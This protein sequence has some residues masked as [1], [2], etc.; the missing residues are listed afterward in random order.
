MPYRL[1][2][3]TILTAFSLLVIGGVVLAAD[4]A[5]AKNADVW[6]VIASRLS[7]SGLLDK[8]R[9]GEGQ[10]CVEAV[11][12]ANEGRTQEEIYDPAYLRDVESVLK[13]G[14]ESGHGPSCGYVASLY[15]TGVGVDKDPAAE[16]R[17]WTK[18]CDL[19]DAD[20]CG[21]LG[22]NYAHGR[23]VAVQAETGAELTR[24]ACFQGVNF[25][26]N[27]YGVMHEQGLGVDENPRIAGKLYR[28]AC[29][30]GEEL[31]CG[32]LAVLKTAGN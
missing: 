13:A 24:R 28:L 25:A 26:C 23:G 14:C 27:N 4:S 3:T 19:G 8:C 15:L 30:R 5:V 6:P 29:D 2:V 11:K 18:G 7:D 21:N 16:S 12:T 20:A 10:A 32:N 1:F 22:W 17:Y 9:I 31:A